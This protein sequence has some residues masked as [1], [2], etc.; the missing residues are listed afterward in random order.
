MVDPSVFETVHLVL[1][2]FTSDIG[3]MAKYIRGA[4]IACLVITIMLWTFSALASPEQFQNAKRILN[5]TGWFTFLCFVFSYLSLCIETYI[6]E[7][8]RKVEKLDKLG[9]FKD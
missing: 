1:K 2:P 8:R 4:C 9:R 5:I 3:D 6:V 7:K